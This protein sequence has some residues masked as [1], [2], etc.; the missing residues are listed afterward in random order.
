MKLLLAEDDTM[1]GSGMEKGLTLAG[2]HVDWVHNGNDAIDALGNRSYDVVLLDI[3]LPAP[4]GLT[5]LRWMR[6]EEQHTPVMLVTARDAVPD[7]VAGLNLGADDYLTKPF[8]LDEL[9][10]RIH[11]LAR[12]HGRL[13]NSL[14]Q[15][16]RLEVHPEAREARLA[17]QP[18]SLSQ[19]E[20]D[21]LTAFMRQP[22]VVLSVEQLQK[23]LYGWGEEIASNAVEVHLHYLRRKLGEPWIVNVRGVGYK[24]VQLP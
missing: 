18:L 8:D 14:L 23:Q 12:R 11:A 4:D 3:G 24:L 5:I 7:R 16:G 17:G 22:G 20:F 21:L 1:L 19:R 2:F 10:A 15:L 13:G 6:N 9:C